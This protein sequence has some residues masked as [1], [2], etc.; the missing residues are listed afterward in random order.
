M[1]QLEQL[2]DLASGHR[3][4]IHE[5]HLSETKKAACIKYGDYKAIALD[6]PCI[7]NAAEEIALLAEEIGHFET[8]SLYFLEATSN[9]PLARSNRMKCEAK[10]KRWAYQRVLPCN[11]IL[12]AIEYGAENDYEVSEYCN[13]P[14]KFLREALIAYEMMGIDFTLHKT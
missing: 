3:I 6:K 7:N 5:Y 4:H 8:G 9:M 14:I 11:L 12:E 10:A 13:V 1:T 2:Y